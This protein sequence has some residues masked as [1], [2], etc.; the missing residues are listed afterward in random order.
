PVAGDYA[1]LLLAVFD[2]GT[3]DIDAWREWLLARV[4]GGQAVLV[5][6]VRGTGAIIPRAINPRPF[7][8]HHGT[9][10]KLVTDL[11]CQGDSLE[12]IRIYDLLRAVE[13]VQGDP[14]ID[15]GGGPGAPPR[16]GRGPLPAWL[17]PPPPPSPPPAGVPPA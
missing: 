2:Q 12:A 16:G 9:I 5:L 3:S 8:G 7:E 10:Y 15:I 11:L 6:D 4:R 14:E 17:P 1:S 13:L